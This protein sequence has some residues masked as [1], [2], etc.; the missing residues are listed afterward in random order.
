MLFRSSPSEGAREKSSIA[1][2]HPNDE[3]I[4]NDPRVLFADNFESGDLKKWDEK[5]DTIAIV[6]DAP[7]NGKYCVHIPMEVGK[8]HGGDAIKWFMPGADK[9]YARIYVKF[10]KNYQYNHHFIWL[11]ANQAKNKWSAF[12]KAGLKPNGTYYSTGMEP[13]F[14]WGKNPSPGE[15]NFYSYYLDMEPDPK[16]P[17]KYWGNSFYPPGPGKGKSAG[18]DRVVP[19]LGKW[20]CWEFML[21]ANT[22]PDKADGKQ[23]MWLDG[24]LIGDFTGI[25]WREDMDLKVNCFWMEHYGYDEGDPTRAYWKDNQAV[26]FDDV[27]IAREYIGP[28]SPR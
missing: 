4:A 22:A 11:G 5:R 28:V 26:W 2:D 10:S 3:G 7:N 21:Q 23:T 17:G 19:Q 20:Q 6:Q 25:R 13:A 27:V 12:G 15:I 16:M 14:A 8:N 9:I 18:P 1:A 24:K